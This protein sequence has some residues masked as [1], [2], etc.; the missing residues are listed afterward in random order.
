MLSARHN[1]DDD[2]DDGLNASQQSWTKQK[3]PPKTKTKKNKQTESPRGV[4]VNVL[5]CKTMV[6]EFELQSC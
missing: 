4:V 2:D 5:D 6:R 1:D 3:T